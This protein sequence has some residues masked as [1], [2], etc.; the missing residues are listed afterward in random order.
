[1][2]SREE[3]EEEGR[4][5]MKSG[6]RR[7]E[8]M[9]Y[10][11]LSSEVNAIVNKQPHEVHGAHG[12]TLYRHV[13]GSEVAMLWINPCPSLP[14]DIKMLDLCVDARDGHGISSS[15]YNWW[16]DH[17]RVICNTIQH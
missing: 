14:C 16:Q 5:K 10:V 13:D 4:T 6:K 11:T 17:S 1:M 8:E 2:L 15:T 12:F 9:K 7:D 3:E